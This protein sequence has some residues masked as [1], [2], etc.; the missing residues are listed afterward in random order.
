MLKTVKIQ[1]EDE[2]KKKKRTSRVNAR[3]S[4]NIN[5]INQEEIKTEKD[6]TQ[7]Q[8]HI[9]EHEI[10]EKPE[11]ISS[12]NIQENEQTS[13]EETSGK[14]VIKL[15][16]RETHLKDKMNKMQFDE[17]LLSGINKGIEG[18]LKSLKE[19]IMSNNVNVSATNNKKFVN[20]SFDYALSENNK[21]DNFDVKK[22]YKEIYEL[23]EEKD[24]LN[25]KLMQ[26]IENE[27]LL[28]NKNKS[29]LLV[30]QNLKEKIKKDVSKQK[31]EI[32]D[33]INII[34]SKIKLLMQSS[35]DANTKRLMNLKSFL[36]NF[37]RDKE[38]AE[39]R[40][41]KYLKENKQRKQLYI[42]NANLFEEKLKQD[43]IQKDKEEKE[44]QKQ[45]VLKLRKQAK[46]LESKQSK[47]IEQKSLL[48]KPFINQK[49][50]KT[51]NYLFMK[52][53]E[54]FIKNEQRLIDKENNLRKNYMKPFSKEEIDEFIEKM[55]KK[56]EEKKLIAEEKA[57]KLQQEW[58]E[59]EKIIQ[60][61]VS[62]FLEKAFE[63]ITNDIKEEKAK[64]EQRNFLLDIKKGYGTE[65]RTSHI[66]PKNKSL[67]QKRLATINNLDPRRF[68][69]NKDTLQHHKRKGRV[70]LKKVDPNKPS[71]YDW[72]KQ[73]N[74][75]A[76]NDPNIDDKLIKKPK[77]YMLS[78]SLERNKRNKLPNIKFDYL[79]KKNN[80]KEQK[81]NIDVLYNSEDKD[82]N[83]EEN[84]IKA[85]AKKWDKLIN[86]SNDE[87]LIENINNAKDKIQKLEY[88]ALQNEKLMK[89]SDDI[90]QSVELNKRVSNLI[91]DSIQAKITLLQKM[92]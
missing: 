18:Q 43:M 62:P 45:L 64:N 31:K 7:G 9:P 33:K 63:G 39:I 82:L 92:K 6:Y 12:T 38:I 80:E 22:K 79:R 35:E 84:Y 70:L 68:L 21:K 49:V 69:L 78:M 48:Y 76:E 1:K 25:R 47:K 77:N 24:A 28:E 40:A 87:N 15:K 27:N 41:K 44:N 74:K 10:S 11:N 59:R 23:K 71:K 32:L 60:Q 54:K 16:P 89:S 34:N 29:N 56:R 5:Q 50:D 81:E 90:N 46:D 72:L 86:E 53:Y 55:D 91:I 8:E 4:K 58:K 85:S 65:I 13:N 42:N 2:P 36:D 61:Y 17:S 67:E 73:L 57:Q 19:D 37:E 66:P 3:S 83:E 14:K 26:I 51:K 52:Q 30:E 75:S 20:K 88:E